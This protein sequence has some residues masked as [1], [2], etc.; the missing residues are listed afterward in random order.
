MQPIESTDS[1]V[2]VASD[3]LWKVVDD[4][5]AV[6]HVHRLGKVSAQVGARTHMCLLCS[7]LRCS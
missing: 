3:G 6:A 2:I 7:A 1:F 5:D 4:L